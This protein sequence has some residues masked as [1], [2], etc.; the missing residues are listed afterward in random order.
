MF[1]LC[2]FKNG[3][4]VA[5]RLRI[6]FTKENMGLTPGEATKIPHAA[7]QLNLDTAMKDPVLLNKNPAC[8]IQDPTQPNK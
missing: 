3:T 5:Q 8:L 2:A 7:E 6:C 1:L 4:C